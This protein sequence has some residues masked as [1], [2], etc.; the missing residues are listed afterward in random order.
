MPPKSRRLAWPEK[1]RPEGGEF[2]LTWGRIAG[3]IGTLAALVAAVPV[4]WALSDHYMN[5]AEIEKALKTH[6]DHDASIQQWNSYGFAANR[7]EYLDDKMA[8]CEAKKMMTQKLPAV[9]AAL[10]TRYDSKFKTKQ[11]EAADLKSKA[12]ESTKERP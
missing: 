3:I 12:M 2:R 7:V 5:R 1:G 4:F 10:C 11:A 9:D 8:E 6:A